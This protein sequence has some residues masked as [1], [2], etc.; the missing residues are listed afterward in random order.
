MSESAAQAR[1]LTAARRSLAIGAVIVATGLAV[2]ASGSQLSGGVLLV[3][4]W[5][6]MLAALHAFGRA[7]SARG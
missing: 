4:G 5:L 2:A 1:R 7:G 6:F 3:F